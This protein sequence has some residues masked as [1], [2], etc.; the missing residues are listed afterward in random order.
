LTPAIRSTLQGHEGQSNLSGLAAIARTSAESHGQDDNSSTPL[1]D[2][3]FNIIQ[4][5]GILQPEEATPQAKTLPTRLNPA[6]K[7]PTDAPELITKQGV[8]VYAKDRDTASRFERVVDKYPDLWIDKGVIDIP[9]DQ[10]MKVPLVE[11]WQNAKLNSRP[12]PLSR[13]DRECLDQ[14]FDP[15]HTAGRMEWVNEPS[16]FAHPVFAVWRTVHGIEKGRE[17]ID[18]RQLNKYGVPDAYPL[19]LQQE[20][21][22]EL[23]GKR[24]V[25]VIDATSFFYQL[26]VHPDYR[27]RFTLI[28]P[29]GIER[30]NVAPMG[31]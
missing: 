18:L 29:R 5:S 7:L 26:A 16:P 15:L 4:S 31:Y 2:A 9:L 27:D 17:V 13:K 12:Y 20:I 25:S 19:P 21:I 28:S 23:R 1:S 11:G 14:T 30:F 24:C 6:I 10:Q 22:Q 3:V 8:H